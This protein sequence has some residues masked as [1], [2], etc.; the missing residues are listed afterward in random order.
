MSLESL[1]KVKDKKDRILNR[2]Y[3]MKLEILMEKEAK[4]L[5]RCIYCNTL[6]QEDLMDQF[7]NSTSCVRNQISIDYNGAVK[8]DHI[9]DR[10]FEMN[11]FILH[12]KSSKK[13][14][15]KQ[16]YYKILSFTKMFECTDCGQTV[17]GPYLK[18]CKFHP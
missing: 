18:H 17:S 15:W 8:V 12:L 14:S 1:E 2:I 13:L 9:A 6:Y 11:K 10:S 16:I 3:M 4:S 7:E 5:Q